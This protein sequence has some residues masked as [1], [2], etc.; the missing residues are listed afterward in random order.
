MF[1]EQER[2]IKIEEKSKHWKDKNVIFVLYFKTI[3]CGSETN[4]FL[5]IYLS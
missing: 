3:E 5:I 2:N 1:K 4:Q